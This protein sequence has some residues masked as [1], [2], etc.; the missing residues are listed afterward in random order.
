MSGNKIKQCCPVRDDTDPWRV[1]APLTPRHSTKAFAVSKRTEL[2]SRRVATPPRQLARSP[3]MATPYTLPKTT[4]T[5][6]ENPAAGPSYCKIFWP[7]SS[8]LHANALPRSHH[9]LMVGTNRGGSTPEAPEDERSGDHCS[10][11]WIDGTA[12]VRLDE[13]CPL[14]RAFHTSPSAPQKP[15]RILSLGAMQRTAT[16][17]G[18]S[19][20]LTRTQFKI[21]QCLQRGRGRLVH[22][23]EILETVWGFV[24]ML[25]SRDLIR[26]HIRNLRLAFRRA[27][28]PD[29]LIQSVRSYGYRLGTAPD[30]R[31]IEFVLSSRTKSAAD[32]K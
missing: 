27:G 31:R 6:R 25:G 29:D 24:P 17:D 12:F 11:V 32:S 21:L 3:S 8:L 2:S 15:R 16:I 7:A 20:S 10:V 19:A 26:A 14:I 28:L 30:P 9:A 5:A 22:Y 13:A 4:P 18:R 1:G 23:E